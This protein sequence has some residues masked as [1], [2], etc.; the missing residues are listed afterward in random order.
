MKLMT[1]KGWNGSRMFFSERVFFKITLL[2]NYYYNP[3]PAT[4]VFV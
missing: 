3:F 1:P 4:L 2:V